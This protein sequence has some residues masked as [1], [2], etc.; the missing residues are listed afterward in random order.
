MSSIR[1]RDTKPEIMVRSFLYRKGLRYRLYCDDLPGKPDLVLRK[2]NCV[3]FVHGCFWHGHINSEC[4]RSNIPKSNSD[5]WI[6][7]IKKNV[8]RDEKNI[9]DLKKLGWRVFILWECEVK[10]ELNLL[11]LLN[12]IQNI[13]V[14]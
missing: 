3:V 13:N 9:E 10:K 12:D 11:K 2:Y 5:Y 1:S 7:K 8:Q 4:K 6:N 14:F